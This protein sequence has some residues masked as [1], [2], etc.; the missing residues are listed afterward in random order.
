MATFKMV[1]NSELVNF[2]A[3]QFDLPKWSLYHLQI[4]KTWR[5]KTAACRLHI[6]CV[7][8]LLQEIK[9]S[10]RSNTLSFC[11]ECHDQYL[12]VMPQP[13]FADVDGI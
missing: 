7:R 10:D 2:N 3:M 9:Q 8:N 12:N 11:E 5:G 4:K 13:N 6:Y 1:F